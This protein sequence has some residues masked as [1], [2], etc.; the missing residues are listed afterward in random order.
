MLATA[1]RMPLEVFHRNWSNTGKAGN[2]Y[3]SKED[4]EWKGRR[5]INSMS[6]SGCAIN[7]DGDYLHERERERERGRRPIP[8][9]CY[10]WRLPKW[11]I[12]EKGDL[13]HVPWTLLS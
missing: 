12:E 2:S 13:F 8:W 6:S 3:N 9:V 11:E 10:R 7:G 5:V 1:T 4:D